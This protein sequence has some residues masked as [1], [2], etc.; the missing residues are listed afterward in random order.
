MSEKALK[1]ILK[2][3][4]FRPLCPMDQIGLPFQSLETDTFKNCASPNEFMNIV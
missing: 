4:F 2:N 3:L 1:G